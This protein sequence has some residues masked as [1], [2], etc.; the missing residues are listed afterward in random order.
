MIILFFPDR[1]GWVQY[2]EIALALQ[3]EIIVRFVKGHP[4]LELYL[5][6]RHRIM[7]MMPVYG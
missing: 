2:I 6:A 4:A 1:D 7:A 3:S 5:E